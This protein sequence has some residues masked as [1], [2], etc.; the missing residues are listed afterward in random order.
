MDSH[1]RQCETS[2]PF[3]HI[4]ADIDDVIQDLESW[5]QRASKSP[6]TFELVQPADRVPLVRPATFVADIQQMMNLFD[7]S[8]DETSG[9]DIEEISHSF[10]FG[11][12]Q[13]E[14]IAESCDEP[15]NEIKCW[16]GKSE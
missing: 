16:N 4:D 8:H 5:R 13:V 3:E 6:L 9:T 10:S 2:G 7:L 12:E 14:N 15:K 1:R 11:I